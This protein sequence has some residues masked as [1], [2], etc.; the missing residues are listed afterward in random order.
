MG[1]LCAQ[2]DVEKPDVVCITETWLGED[3]VEVECT[4][5]GYKCTRLDRN[6]HG[7]GLALFISNKLEFQVTLYGPRGLE[8]LIVS[9]HN[10]N[11]T[12]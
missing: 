8:F 4:I 6:R 5:P 1:E 11:N 12:Q 3:I 10:A 2:C 9:I 7:S